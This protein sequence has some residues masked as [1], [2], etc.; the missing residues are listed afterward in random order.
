MTKSVLR[1][2]FAA[3]LLAGLAMPVLADTSPVPWPKKASTPVL[4]FSNGNSSTIQNMRL[5]IVDGSPVPWPK[6]F[7]NAPAVQADGLPVPWPKKIIVR[8]QPGLESPVLQADGLP[9]P[10]PKK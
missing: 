1:Y 8:P 9:V 4:Q 3:S 5:L 10:W 2:L 7:I 6:K